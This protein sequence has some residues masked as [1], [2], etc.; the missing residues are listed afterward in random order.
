MKNLGGRS[1]AEIYHVVIARFARSEEST[2][3]DSEERRSLSEEKLLRSLSEPV[4][5]KPTPRL[6]G[7]RGAR[8]EGT[9]GEALSGFRL[10]A[11]GG[12]APVQHRLRVLRAA[13]IHHLALDITGTIDGIALTLSSHTERLAPG[14]GL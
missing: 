14:T 5:G 3:V 11:Q 8:G 4:S 9:Q 2:G 6:V 1:P 7:T 10:E 12:G 13:E